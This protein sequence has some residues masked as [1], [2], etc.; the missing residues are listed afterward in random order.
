MSPRKYMYVRPVDILEFVEDAGIC[1]DPA[2]S[3]GGDADCLGAT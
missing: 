1:D 3:S 2:E